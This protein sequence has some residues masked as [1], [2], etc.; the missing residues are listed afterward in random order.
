MSII[1]NSIEEN[2]L[3]D[4]GSLKKSKRNKFYNPWVTNGIIAS[5][6]QKTL[7][8][9][10][11]K[12]TCS[13]KDVSGDKIKYERY[14]LY[15][16]KLNKLIKLSKNNYLQSLVIL[17]RDLSL[18]STLSI[19]PTSQLE[20]RS[21]SPAIILQLLLLRIAIESSIISLIE[22]LAHQIT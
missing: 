6:Q 9:R 18:G 11:W 8:Y 4:K 22:Y 17:I 7:F 14:K 1:N 20:E 19:P 21:I 10:Q 2:F 5:I 13:K 12:R 16:L 3:L 15:R